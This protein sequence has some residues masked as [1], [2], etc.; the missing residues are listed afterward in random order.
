[1]NAELLEV[2]IKK[3]KSVFLNIMYSDSQEHVINPSL[4]ILSDLKNAINAIF[5]DN[6]CIDVIYT[7]NT[8]NQFFG[9]KI[10][11]FMSAQD[12]VTMLFS[13]N[14][15]RL[16]KYQLELDSKLFE[17]GLDDEEITAY[18]LY[19]ISSMMDSEEL[20][21]SIRNNIDYYLTTTDDS[22]TINDSI[23]Y[24]Q[25]II[26]ALKDTM[27]KL[28]S[29]M[30]S[31]EDYIVSNPVIQ[32]A[33]FAEIIKSAKTKIMNGTSGIS[34][35]T[36]EKQTIILQ[37][38]LTMYKNMKINSV[39]I[40]DALKDAALCTGSKLLK[41]EIDK[42]IEAV[43]RIDM[44]FLPESANPTKIL[45]NGYESLLELSLFKALKKNGL[46]SIED[47][48]YEFAMRVKN[49][50]NADDAYVI[51]R[52]INS[53]LGILDDY[54][55]TEDL[56]EQERAHWERVA[57][58]YRDLRIELSKKKFKE[59]TWG[60]FMNYNDLDNLDKTSE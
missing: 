13:D 12:A 8:D 14:K 25:L 1:M 21:D 56:K 27:Y 32:A 55:R 58:G 49:C 17:I 38:M 44:A 46:R 60:I 31:D 9:I 16:V 40:I 5:T 36:K 26:F 41:K 4:T 39:I 51:L 47:D 2:N 43:N 59:K 29:I 19:E 15:M 30:F 6:S 22:I 3:L 28:S 45:E 7:F 52:G 53:R 34:V 42:T 57:Q 37:W 35:T 48:L 23:N 18:L 10:N 54:I 20:F 33:N 50:N 24:A 11:P